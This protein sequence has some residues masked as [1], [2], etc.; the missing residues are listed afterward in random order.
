MRKIDLTNFQ[1]A[2]SE[3]ARHIN[4]RIALNIVRRNQPMSRADLARRS[5]MQRSTVSAIVAQLIDEG[6][7]TEGAIGPS[8]RGRRPRLLHLNVER[9]GVFAVDVRP[10][11]TSVGLAGID[12]RFLMQTTW[13]TPPK[14]AAFAATLADTAQ[15]FRKAHREIVWE[16]M[17]VS[18]PG[19]VDAAGHLVFAP[20]LGWGGVDLRRLLESAIGLPL[21]MENAAS[22]CA[23]AELWFGRHPEH[24]RHLVAVTV[25]EG[26]GVGMLLNGQLV[27]GGEAMAGEFGHVTVDDDGPVCGCGK[28]GCWEQYASNLAALRYYRGEEA[29]GSPRP[30]GSPAGP[31]AAFADLLGLAERG[32]RRAV[33]TLERQ[34]RYLGMGVAALVTG[35]APQVL[36]IVGEITAAWSRV[37]PII[38][39]I[40]K[41]RSLPQIGTTIVPT[42]PGTQPRLRGA[43]TLVVQQ[44]FGAPNV[45]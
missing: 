4:R 41:K 27:H 34:A 11:T 30:D 33:D 29:A 10:Q 24:I 15:A 5:G 39:D 16:G 35:L 37:G 13:P 12:A 18:L 38:T 9:A 6:W 40:V 26:I 1:V 8:A 17:G 31:G 7:L 44:H 22:A 14:P 20:N 45:A 2:T 36:V 32:D 3:T 42:D 43:V 25:S 23:L 21:V 28:R 19:R